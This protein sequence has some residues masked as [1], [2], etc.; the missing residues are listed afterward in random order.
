[1]SPETKFHSQA[2]ADA[3]AAIIN[4][5]RNPDNLP[6]KLAQVV[7]AAGGNHSSKYSWGN[8]FLVIIHG[9]SDAA[10]FRQW[11]DYGRQVRKGSKAFPILAPIKRT[12]NKDTTGPDGTIRTERVSY[13]AG[14]KDVKVFGLESTDISDP[15]KWEKFQGRGAASQ[16]II[17]AAP[18]AVLAGR[19]GF[20]VKADGHLINRGALG[21]YSPDTKQLRL[22]VA[23]LSTWAHEL[24]HLV[25]DGLGNM[26]TRYGQQ[27]D[28]EIVAELGGAILLATIASRPDAGVEASDADLGGCWSYISSY[29]GGDTLQAA[30]K[31]LNRTLEAVSYI[32]EA[33][34]DETIPAPGQPGEDP[35][36]V[37]CGAP[38]SVCECN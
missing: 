2:A 17:E 14:W 37:A 34:E 12:F 30:A 33:L 15:A 1:M 36:C 11:Q 31:L 35:P 10:G 9:Y 16:R 6:A 8:Q 38:E 22:A 18:F 25:D 19:W 7:L 3:A 28:N 29:G 23:N 4:A 27:P 24:V 21:C 26:V 13:V 20:E 5:F 32:L